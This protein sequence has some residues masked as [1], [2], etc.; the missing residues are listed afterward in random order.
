MRSYIW[1]N[2][3]HLRMTVGILLA[4]QDP[5]K[6]GDREETQS[7]LL[8]VDHCLTSLPHIRWRLHSVRECFT[9]YTEDVT[10]FLLY[11]L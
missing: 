6:H 9:E 10:L 3:I 5:Q 1:Q 7:L 2:D 11:V 4:A 8:N